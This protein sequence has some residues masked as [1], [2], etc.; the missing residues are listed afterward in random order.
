MKNAYKTIIVS[1]EEVLRDQQRRAANAN[2]SAER[3]TCTKYQLVCVLQKCHQDL[4]KRLYEAYCENDQL[5]FYWNTVQELSKDN[6]DF[7]KF[8]EQ[9]QISEELIDEIFKKIQ[10]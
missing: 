7:K 6:E 1:P 3:R 5:K 2:I 8:S 10:D 9:L 4:Y